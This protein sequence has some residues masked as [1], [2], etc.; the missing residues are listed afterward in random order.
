MNIIAEIG[1]TLVTVA[2]VLVVIIVGGGIGAF[3]YFKYRAI[4]WAKI[5][6]GEILKPYGDEAKKMGEGL[7]R[8]AFEK[9][10]DHLTKP[11]SDDSKS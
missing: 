3:F 1:G 6:A 9:T 4:K 2:V 5:K 11:S 10:R 8:K 7:A